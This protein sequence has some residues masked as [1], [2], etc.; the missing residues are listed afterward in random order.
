MSLLSLA[1]LLLWTGLGVGASAVG[2]PGLGG[3]SAFQARKAETLLY[4]TWGSH[5]QGELQEEDC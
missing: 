5:P 1:I 4:I 2:T 3:L